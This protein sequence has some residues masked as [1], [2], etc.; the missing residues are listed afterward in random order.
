MHKNQDPNQV[1]GWR[2]FQQP[3]KIDLF[4]VVQKQSMN[5]DSE[6][7]ESL[8]HVILLDAGSSVVATCK[9][10]IMIMDIRISKQPI[11][12]NANAGFKVL[13]L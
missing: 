5:E 11:H 6:L 12:M 4:K 8:K 10:P 7:E 3:V 9:I 1:S 13:G 2:T